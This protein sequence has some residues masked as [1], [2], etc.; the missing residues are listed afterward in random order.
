MTR[1]QLF[2]FRAACRFDECRADE[3]RADL[4][5]IAPRLAARY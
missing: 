1:M 5:D 3:C 4:I 2:A